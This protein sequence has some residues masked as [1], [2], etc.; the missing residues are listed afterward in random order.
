MTDC[1]RHMKL[2]SFLNSDMLLI[3]LQAMSFHNRSN[4]GNETIF[5]CLLSILLIKA[6]YECS[7]HSYLTFNPYVQPRKSMFN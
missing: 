4:A 7:T 5:L 1:C 3:H 2:K 6:L